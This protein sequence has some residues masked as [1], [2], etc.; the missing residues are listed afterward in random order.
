M[1]EIEAVRV[2]EEARL[3]PVGYFAMMTERPPFNQDIEQCQT[4]ESAYLF[5]LEVEHMRVPDELRFDILQ[6]DIPQVHQY[7]IERIWEKVLEM[8]SAWQDSVEALEYKWAHAPRTDD[9]E[10]RAAVKNT[11]LTIRKDLR[12]AL[13]AIVSLSPQ[14]EE[15]AKRTQL[16][17]WK[18]EERA[19]RLEFYNADKNYLV[20]LRLYYEM[21][22]EPGK[23]EA[24]EM[25]ADPHAS[26]KP[27]PTLPFDHPLRWE[28]V[29]RNRY[30]RLIDATH[31]AMSI[32][33]AAHHEQRARRL[34]KVQKVPY[35]LHPISVEMAYI[36]DTVPF[37]IE[38]EKMPHNVIVGTT[39]AALHDA[40]EDTQLTID[41]ILR[42]FLKTRADRIDSRIDQAIA[43]GFGLSRDEFKRKTLHF[44][45]SE[46]IDELRA[47]LGALSH[48]TV[49][50]DSEKKRALEQNIAGP[51]QTM[52]LVGVD[53]SKYAAWGL[54]PN[55]FPTPLKAFS[56]FP[57]SYERDIDAFLVRLNLLGK[58]AKQHALIIKLEDRAH[59]LIDCKDLP[60]ATQ[61]KKLRSTIRL[62]AYAMCDYL[63]RNGLPLYNALPRLIDITMREY[64]RFRAEN[65]ELVIPEDS[66]FM[67]F[68]GMWHRSVERL[69]LPE[70]AEAALSTYPDVI[71]EGKENAPGGLMGLVR[72]LIQRVRGNY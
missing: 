5:A 38:Q 44:I 66:G 14:H 24:E 61:A 48:N 42:D 41:D 23:K 34:R 4:P 52:E 2:R 31:Q 50:S 9:R 10:A 64:Q 68:L 54:D 49:L 69:Q 20:A 30:L 60:P 22:L 28:I 12:Q 18:T 36:L 1:T 40:G 13:T 7:R 57:R 35:V 37:V 21:L 29:M 53:E 56:V 67:D 39:A 19:L 65:P 45:R 58:K 62:I 46:V 6:K 70:F 47:I 51:A 33:K 3:L 55:S 15:H 43:S 71:S 11:P 59:N 27:P 63:P 26:S 25:R 8:Q 17:Q 72:Q 16:R 32:A